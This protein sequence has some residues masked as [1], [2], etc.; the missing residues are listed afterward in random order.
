MAISVSDN[1]MWES[2]CRVLG[3]PTW[4]QEPKFVNPLERKKNEGELDAKISEWTANH[5]PEELMRKLQSVGVPAGVV[6]NGRDLAENAE[7]KERGALW[8]LPHEELGS[9][10]HLGQPFR[11]SKT[12]AKGYRASPCLGMHNEYVCSEIL[13]TS[14]A[15][16]VDFLKSGA[17]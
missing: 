13:G 16:F 9:F 4:T 3:N 17:F 2:F 15:E 6:H 14:D 1:K 11:L 8:V 5:P 12:P 7:L 10:T